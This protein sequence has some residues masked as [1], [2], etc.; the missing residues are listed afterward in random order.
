MRLIE[1]ADRMPISSPKAPQGPVTAPTMAIHRCVTFLDAAA[2]ILYSARSLKSRCSVSSTLG[3]RSV[4][5][6]LRFLT[7][8]S[9]LTAAEAIASVV[10]VNK[11]KDS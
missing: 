2:S 11:S 5:D 9:L 1:A 7:Y 3:S 4:L 10:R 8:P 6:A